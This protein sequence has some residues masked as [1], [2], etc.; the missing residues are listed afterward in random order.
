MTKMEM[1][2]RLYSRR[3]YSFLPGRIELR[4]LGPPTVDPFIDRSI[5]RIGHDWC[6]FSNAR[7]ICKGTVG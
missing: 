3:S 5:G 1:P 6:W 4:P 7:W 2:L